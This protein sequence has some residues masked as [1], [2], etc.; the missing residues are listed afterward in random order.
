MANY[1]CKKFSPVTYRLATIHSLRTTTERW[2]DRRL[3]VPLARPL[4]KYDRLKSFVC[5]VIYTYITVSV[6]SVIK[7][8]S[9]F[10]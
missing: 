5:I 10:V 2:T 8:A 9:R 1:S 4:L 6:K 3:L 7:K